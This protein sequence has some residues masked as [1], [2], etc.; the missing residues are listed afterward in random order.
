L[1]ENTDAQ[2]YNYAGVVDILKKR[3]IQQ[4][5]IKPSQDSAHG[6][7]VFVCYAVEFDGDKCLLKRYDGTRVDLKDILHATPLLFESLIKQ[8]E[9][10]AS[11][12][13]TSVNTIRMM[14][15][16]YPDNT[17]RMYAV[18][19]KIGRQGSDVDNAGDGGNVNCKIDLATGQIL[20]SVEFNSWDNVREITHHPDSDA[21]LVGEYIHNWDMIVKQVCSFQARMPQL[22]VICWDVAITE[23]G[24][25]IIEFNN[26]WDPTGQLFI[27]KGWKNEVLECYNA[28][29]RDS[30]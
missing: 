14:T 3:N 25:M 5:V 21:K 17:V 16:L 2:A 8:S 26:W 4:C 28:W 20:S 18:W 7:G 12:N 6:H 15:A 19:M 10:F 30:N 13:S 22:K 27:G 9:Q 24:P 11:F 1:A 29:H 23:H